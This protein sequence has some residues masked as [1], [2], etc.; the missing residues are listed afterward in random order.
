MRFLL[1]ACSL[2]T[3]LLGGCAQLQPPPQQQPPTRAATINDA[4]ARIRHAFQRDLAMCGDIIKRIG[5]DRGFIDA[6]LSAGNREAES[7][8]GLIQKSPHAQT[9]EYTYLL[10]NPDTIDVGVSY[11]GHPWAVAWVENEAIYCAPTLERMQ[12]IEALGESAD[13]WQVRE[14]FLDK[15]LQHSESSGGDTSDANKIKQGEFQTLV[16][17]ASQ[18]YTGEQRPL[19]LAWTR[20]A[21]DTIER[22]RREET[23]DAPAGSAL[24]AIYEQLKRNAPPDERVTFLRGFLEDTR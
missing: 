17:Q 10:R 23:V 24:S 1:V 14:F 13:G 19:F 8:A 5:A 11:H 21:I 9:P 18:R 7:L 3:L 22:Q 15:A 20:K 2:S 16:Q 6:F 4:A 12:D